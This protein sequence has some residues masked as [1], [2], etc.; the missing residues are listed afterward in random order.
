ML[1]PPWLEMEGLASFDFLFPQ[2]PN[3]M[4][5]KGI[6]NEKVYVESIICSSD[7]NLDDVSLSK[8]CCG[9]ISTHLQNKT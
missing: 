7:A 5:S 1:L 4:S 9:P 8:D 6:I 2:L 3:A